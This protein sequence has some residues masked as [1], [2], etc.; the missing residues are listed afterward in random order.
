[1]RVGVGRRD[2]CHHHGWKRDAEGNDGIAV[3]EEEQIPEDGSDQL[4]TLEEEVALN[5]AA[6]MLAP[7]WLVSN[8]RPNSPLRDAVALSGD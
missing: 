1:L 5:C 8:Q 3:I 6:S 2:R 4:K 7:V